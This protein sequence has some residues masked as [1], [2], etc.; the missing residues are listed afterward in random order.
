M[1]GT[2]GG[3]HTPLKIGTAV[4]APRRPVAGAAAARC[5]SGG[6]AERASEQRATTA[7]CVARRSCGDD[8]PPQPGQPAHVLYSGSMSAPVLAKS[9]RPADAGHR[10]DPESEPSDRRG[11]HPLSAVRTG[12]RRRQAAGAARASA[13]RNLLRGMRHRVEH[14]H[15]RGRCPGCQHQWQWTTC[16][17]CGVA[18]LHEHWYRRRPTR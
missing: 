16:L 17:S 9:G 7:S 15:T 8:T 12:A 10:D 2:Y 5:L 6:A 4:R 3:I 14:V 11:R 1:S 18:S 13:H